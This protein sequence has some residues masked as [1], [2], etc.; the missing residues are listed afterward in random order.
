MEVDRLIP[1]AAGDPYRGKRGRGVPEPVAASRAMVDA[2]RRHRFFEG[3]ARGILATGQ[4]TLL[5]LDDL[6]WC[7][8]ETTAWFRSCSVERLG[9]RCWSPQRRDAGSWQTTLRY[10]VC[11][12]G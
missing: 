5:V 2:W 6:Q 11:C 9:R 3:L 4:P 10:L 12:L 7:D 8:D 1:G